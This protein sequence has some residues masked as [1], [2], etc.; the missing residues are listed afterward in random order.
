MLWIVR[1]Q[2]CC[3]EIRGNINPPEGQRQNLT[4]G[5]AEEL[6]SLEMNGFYDSPRSPLGC[7]HGHKA[8]AEGR[9]CAA[10]APTNASE[11]TQSISPLSL[12]SWRAAKHQQAVGCLL[13]RAALGGDCTTLPRG[14]AG[15]GAR[16][17]HPCGIVRGKQPHPGWQYNPGLVAPQLTHA[18]HGIPAG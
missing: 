1:P 16:S 14:L 7:A 18:Q 2:F 13:T 8:A 12:A 5:R 17:W 10:T 11:L 9:L 3:R 15:P 4:S 6:A